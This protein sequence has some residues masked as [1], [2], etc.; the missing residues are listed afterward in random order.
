MC[1][2]VCVCV[3][4]YICVCV[5]IYIYIYIY[6]REL[7]ANVNHQ[8]RSCREFP[9][10]AWGQLVTFQTYTGGFFPGDNSPESVNRTLTFNLGRGKD[11]VE[12]HTNL[13]YIFIAYCVISMGAASI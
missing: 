3:Y 10:P 7:W 12:L 13:P 5:Y 6:T 1:V 8:L 11:C 2:C 9:T 4:I